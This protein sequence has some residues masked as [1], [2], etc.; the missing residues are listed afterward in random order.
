MGL[1]L[2]SIEQGGNNEDDRVASAECVP[3]HLN[4]YVKP[5][6]SANCSIIKLFYFSL[7]IM[8]INYLGIN[9]DLLYMITQRLYICYF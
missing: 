8:N 3:I 9:F 7:N 5:H 2:T 1:E 6:L 4:K